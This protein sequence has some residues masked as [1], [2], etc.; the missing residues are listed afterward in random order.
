M[1]TSAFRYRAFISYSHRDEGWASWLHKSLER[2]RVPRRLVGRSTAAGVVAPRIAPVFRDREELPSATDLSRVV[3]AALESSAAL[4]VICSPAAAQ[5][6]W[7]N[8]EIRVF[9][10]LGRSDHIFCLIIGGEPGGNAGDECFPAALRRVDAAGGSVEPIAADIR[11]GKDGKS[12]A[13]LKIVAGLIGVGLDDLARRE[14]QRRQ[15][16]LAAITAVSVAGMAVTSLLAAFALIARNDAEHQ[17]ARAEVQATTAQQTSEFLVGLFEVADPGEARGNSITAREILDRGAMRIDRDLASQP[18]VRANLMQTM[19]RVYT[20]LGLYSPATDLL[21]RAVETRRQLREYATTDGVAAANAL[22]LALREKGEYDAARSVFEESLAAARALAP[23]GDTQVSAALYGL[24]ELLVQAGDAAAAETDYAA[25]LAIDR[26]L[27]RG[28][29]IGRSLAGLAKALLFQEQYAESE[30]AFR[31]SLAV[32][33]DSLGANHP[34]VALTLSDL[35]TMLYFSGRPDEAEPLY[36]EAARLYEGI[37]GHEH[38]Y[39]SSIENNLGRLLLERGELTEAEPL[40][41]SALATDRK[42]HDAGHDDLVY[43]LN[44]LALVRLGLGRADIALP[45][46]EEARDIAEQQQNLVMRGEVWANL[47]DVYW[48]VGRIA[49]ARTAIAASRGAFEAVH[50]DEQTYA[51]NLASIEGAV[52]V[53]EGNLAEAERTLSSSYAT[54][55]ERWGPRG[56]FTQLAATRVAELEKVR[57]RKETAIADRGGANGR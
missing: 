2:Y 5:S 19:G 47:A 4:I 28:A 43:T 44:N 31:E 40:L 39:V 57:G 36:R 34:L 8:E 12:N 29:D 27:Q 42:F 1:E 21:S 56:L 38:Q 15:R 46:F 41:S 11:P 32:R 7:V 25:A 54:I 26:R 48:R 49:D 33:L 52:L 22:G 3:T 51:A 14:Q 6:R 53:A 20:S 50:P 16:R 17:R 37:L 10:Q 35:G 9:Q 24:G 45:L 30:A 13:L 18:E 23:E 55:E